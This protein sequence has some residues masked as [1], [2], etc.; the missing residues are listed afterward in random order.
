MSEI[1]I[2]RKIS[3]SIILLVVLFLFIFGVGEIV[4]R[5]FS[6]GGYVTPDTMRA[7]SVEYQPAV[8]ARS[9]Y[10][11]LTQQADD[12][13]V[14]INALGYR[15]KSF[16]VKKDEDVVRVVC[17]GGSQVLDSAQKDG[18][19]WPALLE[20]GL[21]NKGVNAE[22]INAGVAGNASCDSLGRF[23]TEIWMLKPDY[24]VICHAW[25]DIK[26][27]KNLSPEK[28]LLRSI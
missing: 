2:R 27:F 15:G 10:P 5:L 4:V 16:A 6:P 9:I 28:S 23:Y 26:Y 25:N 8:F 1:G 12:G 3:F 11:H 18:A 14:H 7:D 13:R 19:D 20:K 17:L 22:V 21:Q 24:V